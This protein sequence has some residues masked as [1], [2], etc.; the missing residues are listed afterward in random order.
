MK[1]LFKIVLALTFLVILIL[2]A[3]CENTVTTDMTGSCAEPTEQSA[4]TTEPVAFCTVVFL[5][6]DGTVLKTQTVAYGA[7]A[8]APT[9]PEREGYIFGGWSGSFLNVT[10]N[11]TVTAT[12]APP[13]HFFLNNDKKSY[14][15]CGD[16]AVGDIVIPDTYNGLPVTS[17]G[18]PGYDKY[19]FGGFSFCKGLTGITIPDSVTFIDSNAFYKCE[20][21]KRVKIGGGVSYVGNN[22]FY[23]CTSLEFSEYENGLYLGNDENPYAMLVGVKNKDVTSF[24]VH[25]DA[26][27]IVPEAFDGITTLTSV[28]LPSGLKSF[29]YGA[30]KGL[31]K[32]RWLKYNRDGSGLY[33]GN[34]ENPYVVLAKA[35]HSGIKSCNVNTNTKI[36]ADQAFSG[37]QK[38]ERVSIPD[39][40]VYIGIHAFDYC[41]SLSEAE[42]PESVAYIGE[43]AF[44]RCEKLS[45]VTIPKNVLFVSRSAFSRCARLESVTLSGGVA[46]ICYGAFSNCKKLE[47]ITIPVGVSYIGEC[48]FNGCESLCEIVYGGTTEQ[49]NAIEKED[50]WNYG[51]KDFTVVCTDGNIEKQ[52]P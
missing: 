47:R 8:S 1:N 46:E 36:I 21:L 42:I 13:L 16:G 14:S 50:G 32:S 49:W 26:T 41:T 33:L 2:L 15:V 19:T 12:Y 51:T 20:N 5:D 10:E 31:S 25:G 52:T 11:I 18:I 27:V 38:L 24:D 29:G 22:V 34:A 40:V 28:S 39:G 35:E 6:D 30:M 9:V 45:A 4:E 43:N 3:S 7:S 23:G 44:V 37:C 17:I 48:A